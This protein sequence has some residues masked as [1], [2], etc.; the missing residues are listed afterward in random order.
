[1]GVWL[2]WGV[3][4][5]GDVVGAVGEWFGLCY[6]GLF[7]FRV[8]SNVSSR[9][10]GSGIFCG[11]FFI[12]SGRSF[13][14]IWFYDGRVAVDVLDGSGDSIIVDYCDP[15]FFGRL[16]NLIDLRMDMIYKLQKLLDG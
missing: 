15:L 3:V 9:V 2:R 1:M 6:G 5:V 11:V 10:V 7:E 13:C 14:Y 8:V 12:D 16:G 4:V